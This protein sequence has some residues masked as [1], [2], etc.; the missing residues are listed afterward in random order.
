MRERRQH[1]VVIALAVL[2]L[3]ALV[4]WLLLTRTRVSITTASQSIEIVLIPRPPAAEP[5]RRTARDRAAQR[6][7]GRSASHSPSS[8]PP[9][10]E[11]LEDTSPPAPVD[12]D[13]ELARAAQNA[14]RAAGGEQPR[15]FGFPKIDTPP[16]Q[17]E[18]AWDYAA[19]HRVE[20]IP[21]GGLLVNLND[22]CVLVFLPLPFVF[23]R[24]GHKP[25]NG[26]LFRGMTQ[27]SLTP[28]ASVT[29]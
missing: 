17:A 2:T 26:E 6:S 16:K 8:P 28:D 15:D 22:N 5:R 12:W 29:P 23:C 9:A 20:R 1:A 25:A 11:P 14:A 13:A 27:K 21:E 24:P 7:S 19:T 10:P 3:H 4:L 18:F